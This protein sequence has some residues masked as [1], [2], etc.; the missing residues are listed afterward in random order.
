MSAIEKIIDE[1]TAKDHAEASMSGWF[2]VSDAW[3]VMPA[4]LTSPDPFTVTVN[5]ERGTVNVEFGAVTSIQSIKDDIEE[6]LD[7]IQDSI[8]NL[9]DAVHYAEKTSRSIQQIKKQIK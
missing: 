2:D 8:T 3:K 4:L 9:E 1:Q 7:Y 6:A 5:E